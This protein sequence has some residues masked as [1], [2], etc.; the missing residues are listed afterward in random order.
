MDLN[1]AAITGL[2]MVGYER[3]LPMWDGLS[4]AGNGDGR[5]GNHHKKTIS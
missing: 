2:K 3:Q 1:T 5:G 4:K